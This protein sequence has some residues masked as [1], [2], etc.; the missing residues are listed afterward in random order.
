MTTKSTI[1]ISKYD[2][3]FSEVIARNG[4]TLRCH[5]A[6][7]TTPFTVT[8]SSATVNF[9]L[10]TTRIGAKLVFDGKE[11]TEVQT[12]K[13]TPMDYSV[14]LSN[15]TNEL[16]VEIRL[17][18]RSFTFINGKNHNQYNQNTR[19]H[20]ILSLSMLPVFFF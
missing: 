18:V 9:Q 19:L 17:K 7:K 14:R 16:V 4:R 13:N 12:L 5:Y 1:K 11:T 3:P 10:P 15:V 20:V 2:T 8:I 6:V